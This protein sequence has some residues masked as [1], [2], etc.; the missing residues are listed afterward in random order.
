MV[1]ALICDRPREFAAEADF[2]RAYLGK[3]SSRD[4]IDKQLKK[5]YYE[6]SFTGTYQSTG[7]TI[8]IS[9]SNVIYPGT[10]K[11]VVLS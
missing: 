4:G 5:T 9:I 10:G 6:N 1:E 3:N 11:P 2:S 7:K 8:T